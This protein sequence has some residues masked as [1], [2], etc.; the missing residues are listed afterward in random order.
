MKKRKNKEEKKKNKA[1]VSFGG[2]GGGVELM[3]LVRAYRLRLPRMKD[4]I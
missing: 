3:G 2:V 4:F 1:I